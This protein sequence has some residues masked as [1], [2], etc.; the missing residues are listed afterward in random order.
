[1]LSS[2]RNRPG[3]RFTTVLE[4][5][6]IAQGWV[7]ARRGQ[8]V[9]GQ[10]VDAKAAGRVQGVSHLGVTLDELVLVDGQQVPI[11]TEM[12][13]SSAGTSMGRDAAGVGATTGIGAIIGGAAGGGEGAAI[14]AAAGAAAG[15]IGVLTTR[16]RP[17]ELY[18]ETVLTF[19]LQNAL[20]VDTSQSQQ[21][22][23][24]V[25]PN[26]YNN[27]GRV[28]HNPPRYPAAESYP[29]PPPYYYPPYYYPARGWYYGYYGYGYGPGFYVAPRI[30]IGGGYHHHHW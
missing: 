2:D 9:Q 28:L 19:R 1:M 5:P 13:R 25:T 6:L 30:I 14:G 4:Q 7:L 12:M 23:L 20:T 15:I 10:V 26:D 8:V 24:P 29:P 21:A 11:R 3:D 27:N 16:G 18:P 22:F 17:T